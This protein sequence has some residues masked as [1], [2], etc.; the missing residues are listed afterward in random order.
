MPH[1]AD[2]M[3]RRLLGWKDYTPV[4]RAVAVALDYIDYFATAHSLASLAALED[5]FVRL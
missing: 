2:R 3:T 1:E 4:A 5:E